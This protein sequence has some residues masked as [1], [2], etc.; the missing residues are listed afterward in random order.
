MGETNEECEERVEEDGMTRTYTWANVVWDNMSADKHEK[1]WRVRVFCSNR[2]RVVRS[3]RL[4][5][6][7]LHSIA[8]LPTL[9]WVLQICSQRT[10]LSMVFFSS[11][12]SQHQAACDHMFGIFLHISSK[13]VPLFGLLIQR[14]PCLPVVSL[15]LG[16][17]FQHFALLTSWETIDSAAICITFWISSRAPSYFCPFCLLPLTSSWTPSH[18]LRSQ[19]SILPN[20]V[21]SLFRFRPPVSWMNVRT[22]SVVPRIAK[23]SLIVDVAPVLVIP[24]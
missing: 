6:H 13:D 7:L 23:K 12:T 3:Q 9:L 15:L 5:L 21:P 16:S 17:L 1:M 19:V 8:C 22:G 10:T 18:P 11:S 24:Q 14:Q 2:T 4:G 20:H